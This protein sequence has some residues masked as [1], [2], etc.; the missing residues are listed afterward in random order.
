MIVIL[1]GVFKFFELFCI[2]DVVWV[3]VRKLKVFFLF[4]L[5]GKDFKDIM[6]IYRGK[7]GFFVCVGVIDGIYVF[8]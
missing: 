7:W 3:I 4:V 1:F 2:K 8:I 6:I 5:E